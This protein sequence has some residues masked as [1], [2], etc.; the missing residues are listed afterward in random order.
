MEQYFTCV[1]GLTTYLP[2]DHADRPVFNAHTVAN[3]TAYRDLF[4]LYLARESLAPEELADAL[5]DSFAARG[6]RDLRAWPILAL[7][8][9]RAVILDPTFFCEKISVGPL[10]H[11]THHQPCRR[12]LR[13]G[14]GALVGHGCRS[15]VACGSTTPTTHQT[16]AFTPARLD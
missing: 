12:N 8:D 11:R 4:Q 5:W 3:A 7:V 9:G 10:F 6:Y 2:F 15:T 1:T 16:V 14:R 13:R